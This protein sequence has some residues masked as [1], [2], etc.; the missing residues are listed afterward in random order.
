MIVDLHYHTCVPGPLRPRELLEYDRRNGLVYTA[1]LRGV[2]AIC[3][4][5]HDKVW[6]KDAVRALTE[7]HGLLVLRGMEVSTNYAEFGHVLVYGLSR[8]IS[9][10][11][12]IKKLAHVVEQEGGAMFVAHPFREV[13]SWD[14]KNWISLLTVQEASEMPI[15]QM[16]QGMEVYNG[17]TQANANEFAMEVCQHLG[18]LGTGGSDAHSTVGVGACATI[19]DNPIKSEE[20]L[21]RELRAGNFRPAIRK[22]GSFAVSVTA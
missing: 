8:Y 20:D 1:R 4:T 22:D 6:E 21:V 14:G 18:L 9:G 19:F 12:D 10:I 17:A 11:W 7:E 13:Y 3:L 15:F 5:E 2:D 16:V